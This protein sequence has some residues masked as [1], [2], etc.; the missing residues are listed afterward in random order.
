MSDVFALNENDGIAWLLRASEAGDRRAVTDTLGVAFHARIPEG[1]AWQ[2]RVVA[3][4]EREVAEGR[5]E[6]FVHRVLAQMYARGQGVER[7]R[8]RAEE[9]AELAAQLG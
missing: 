7:D 3:M 8:A 5:A 2:E 9:Y 6:A 4:G 1:A